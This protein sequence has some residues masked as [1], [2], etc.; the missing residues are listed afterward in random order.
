[1]I[2]TAVIDIYQHLWYFCEEQIVILAYQESFERL[3]FYIWGAC[4]RPHRSSR[5]VEYS[6]PESIPYMKDCDPL[7]RGLGYSLVE[8]VVFK[9]QSTWHVR[10]VI[11][12]QSGVGI[13]DCTKVHRALLPRLE[14]VLQSQ[15]MY[16]EVTSPGLERVLKNASEFSVFTGRG[17]KIW[18]TDI[19]DWIQGVVL[20]A[21]TR[22]VRLDT[23]GSEIEVP[24][25]KINKA[26][27][28]GQP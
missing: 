1:L 5:V 24:F 28:T 18:N 26:K 27:L 21:D 13:Q 23:G 11:A 22:S 20:S 15:D 9:R 10:V 6:A 17:I 7:V 14:A 4:F 8:L 16:V 12:G 3:F 19:S 25:D 2:K